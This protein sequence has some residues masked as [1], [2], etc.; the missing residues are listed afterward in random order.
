MLDVKKLLSKILDAV[1]EE[2]TTIGDFTFTKKG[3]T[4]DVQGW[5]SMSVSSSAY[6]SIGTLPVAFRPTSTQFIIA[7]AGNAIGAN[8]VM[9]ILPSGDVSLL[10][11][12][13]L[14]SQFF[15]A[16]G[17]YMLG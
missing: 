10:G 4:V 1:E 14:S 8:A 5:G 17:V 6:Q 2:I 12:Q 16:S 11:S 9:R 7:V 13:T 3:T 15:A